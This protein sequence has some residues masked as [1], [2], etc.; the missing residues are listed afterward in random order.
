MSAL[1]LRQNSQK[2]HIIE[3]SPQVTQINI[4]PMDTEV[5]DSRK[6]YYSSGLVPD[7]ETLQESS[8]FEDLRRPIYTHRLTTPK[9]EN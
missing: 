7:S 8:S 5:V 2:N 3:K 6:D 1:P 9:K 4:S